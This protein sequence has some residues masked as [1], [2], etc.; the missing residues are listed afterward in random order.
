MSAL[1]AAPF[2]NLFYT[3]GVPAQS[4]DMTPAPHAFRLFALLPDGGLR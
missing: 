2:R 3:G 1:D 4:D